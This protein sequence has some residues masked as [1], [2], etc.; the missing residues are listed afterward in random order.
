[1]KLLAKLTIY[2]KLA[3]LFILIILI[4]GTTLYFISRKY[5][6]AADYYF[7]KISTVRDAASYSKERE[8]KDDENFQYSLDNLEI[9]QRINLINIIVTSA[10]WVFVIVLLIL[11][12][13]VR[14]NTP[15]KL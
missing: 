14:K 2:R 3:I 7:N 11:D 5:S 1:M 12:Y 4:S 10:L 13:R 15:K 9:V 8:M 6:V